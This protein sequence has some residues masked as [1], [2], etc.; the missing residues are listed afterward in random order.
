VREP[1]DEEPAL[2]GDVVLCPAVAAAQA[3]E[4]DLPVADELQLLLVHGILHLLGHDHADPGERAV[5]FR[6][7]DRLLADFKGLQR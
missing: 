7:T 6:L 1:H 5:M 2:L 3:V 4:R